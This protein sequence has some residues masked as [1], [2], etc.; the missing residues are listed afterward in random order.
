M[1]F[2]P[3]DNTEGGNGQAAAYYYFAA[4]GYTDT[5]AM[6]RVTDHEFAHALSGQNG[7]PAELTPE[8]T[9]AF[10]EAC[11]TLRA[12]A[13]EN[14]KQDT[15]TILQSLRDLQRLA[16]K[17]YAPAFKA[18][19]DALQDGTYG[20]LPAAADTN[21]L[22]GIKACY[23][24]NPWY[25]LAESI[26]AQKINGGTIPAEMNTERFENE[27]NEMVEDWHDLVKENTVYN[28]LSESNYIKNKH[29]EESEGL[30]H[31]YESFYELQ[32]STANLIL[33]VPSEFGAHVAKLP[34]DQKKAIWVVVD[35]NHKVMRE[36]KN[37]QKDQEFLKFAE[38]QLA[39][40]KAKA[41]MA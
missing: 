28:V 8:Q 39:E 12:S 7:K 35:H 3:E 14:M 41:E 23:L 40:F 9:Q 18:V 15:A 37:L 33:S 27:V 6:Q 30:G 29:D 22:H 11:T 19:S 24:Q 34:E 25:A 1:H 36:D 38:A 32:A 4:N 5:E 16:P 13:L 10:T 26:R 20:D 17:E 21:P 2:I 31:P